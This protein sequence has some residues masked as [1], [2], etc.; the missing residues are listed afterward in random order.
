M[1]SNGVAEQ[2][3]SDV[4]RL[5]DRHFHTHTHTRQLKTRNDHVTDWCTLILLVAFLPRIQLVE[6]FYRD[7]LPHQH[8]VDFVALQ[9]LCYHCSVESL[10]CP[11]L[12]TTDQAPVPEC[13][14]QLRARTC[15]IVPNVA[16]CLEEVSNHV[17]VGQQSIQARI[18]S[19]AGI[20]T[21]Q[22]AVVLHGGSVYGLQS[23]V[24]C[25]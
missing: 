4:R 8:A 13:K 5:I 20:A 2:S 1:G 17:A 7:V 10:E 6:C 16:G 9:S 12:A 21:A 14:V 11:W 19:G 3:G 15:K 22:C 18:H 23:S 25:L 24:D